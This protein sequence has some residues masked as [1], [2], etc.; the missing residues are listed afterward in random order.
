M[1]E[2]QIEIIYSG[3]LRTWSTHLKSGDDIITD[4][5]VDNQGKGESFSPTDLVASALGSCMLTIM[6]ITADTQNINIDGTS[7]KVKKIMGENPRRISEIH[8]DITFIQSI[9]DKHRTVLERAAH[10]CPVS[11]SLHTDLIEVV[12]FHYPE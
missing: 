3:E 2:N 4:A 7:A 5:P 12:N 6:G 1:V 9:S 10:H 8:L 11:R